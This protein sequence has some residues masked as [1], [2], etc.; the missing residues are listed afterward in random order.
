MLKME[1]LSQE[2][3][4]EMLS[5]QPS[6]EVVELWR[7]EIEEWEKNKITLG[8]LQV[9]TNSVINCGKYTFPKCSDF[10]YYP[11]RNT[12]VI[13][14]GKSVY[15]ELVTVRNKYKIN[16]EEQET[17]YKKCV[18]IVGL[19][20]GF[21]V[22]KA[23]VMSN[24]VGRIKIADFDIV[25]ISN[26]NRLDAG[27]FGLGK[28]K[29][30]LVYRWIKEQNP[31]I[32]I[33]IYE[34]GINN[35]IINEFFE[36]Y[37]KIDVLIDECDSL[38]VKIKLRER[39]RHYKVPVVMHTS[40]RGMLDIENYREDEREFK[41]SFLKY[42]ELSEEQIFANA[43]SIIA[44]VCDLKSASERSVYSFKNIGLSL[45]SWPQLAED[46]VSGGGNVATVVRLLLL[47]NRIASQRVL[48]N[49]ENFLEEIS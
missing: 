41:Y 37:Q 48:L 16:R 42:S 25:E 46:V 8:E 7:L 2:Q 21:Q 22:V 44:E 35:T 45:R 33:D 4:E 17:L 39:A 20:V 38:N 18:G 31:Y 9:D 23:M 47:N 14:L 49:P 27:I 26:L 43:G 24:L 32:D 40:D 13:G 34:S 3:F 12:L 6:V 29:V 11:W 30:E 28:E 19:S 10:I 36:E 5:N 15:R 1:F